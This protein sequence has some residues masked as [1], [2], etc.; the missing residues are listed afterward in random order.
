MTDL[1]KA[2]LRR[3]A[4]AA[5]P[6][7]W[8]V[9]NGMGEVRDDHDDYVCDT[10]EIHPANSRFIAAANPAA[11]LALLDENASLAEIASKFADLAG[12]AVGQRDQL[13]A[14]VEALRVKADC[15]D[16]CAH[17]IRKLVHCR[18]QLASDDALA[19]KALDYL[20]RKGLQGSPMRSEEGCAN[21]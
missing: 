8:F 19:S 14:E 10:C 2:E 4:E 20:K 16:D 17:L 12:E 21:G 1:N 3:I 7:P 13:R 15:V 5:N 18:R 11:I 9:S 6:G